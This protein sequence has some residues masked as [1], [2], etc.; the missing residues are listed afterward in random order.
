MTLFNKDDLEET[1]DV[2]PDSSDNDSDGSWKQMLQFRSNH[3]VRVRT[4]QG[5][6]STDASAKQKNIKKLK[7]AM[8]L[9]YHH[10][11]GC[12]K[13]Q[14]KTAKLS[15]Y[16]G[17]LPPKEVANLSLA[18]STVYHLGFDQGLIVSAVNDARSM[19]IRHGMVNIYKFIQYITE[20]AE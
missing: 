2:G 19:D 6:N 1:T 9:S 20:N 18:Y 17:Y 14:K 10:N 8:V 12:K 7:N 13:S 5:S 3:S 4:K 15:L 16:L 11:E